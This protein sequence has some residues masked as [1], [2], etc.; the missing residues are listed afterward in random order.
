MYI[1]TELPLKKML[2][3]MEEDEGGYVVTICSENLTK[4]GGDLPSVP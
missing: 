2:E 4:L 3:A 1:L